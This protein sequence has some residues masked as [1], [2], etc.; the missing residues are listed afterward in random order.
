MDC[1]VISPSEATVLEFKTGS[2]RADHDRQAALYWSAA[3]AV[4]GHVPVSV[5]I[6]Y[7]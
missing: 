2:A 6:L 3:R 1:V 7:P 4:F 5:K